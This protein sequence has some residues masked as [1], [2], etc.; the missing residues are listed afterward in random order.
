MNKTL[1]LATVLILSSVMSCDDGS[2]PSSTSGAAS[3]DCPLG[4]FKPI[5]LSECV[6]PADTEFGQPTTVSD[7]RCATGQPAIPPSC[8]SDTGRRAYL[9][10]SSTCAPNYHF[11]MG[12]C[13]RG[14]TG[15]GGFFTAGT[16]GAAGFGFA[17]STDTGGF[18]G[19]AGSTGFAG[20]TGFAGSTGEGGATGTGGLSG[21][22][23][24]TGSAGV[25]GAAG[26]TGSDAS[27]DAQSAD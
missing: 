3:G 16:T 25:T 12:L 8:V 18:T 14:N 4:M 10:A 7:N 26:I 20:F 9:S 2:D 17:G 24:V 6:F 15:I 22:S 27:T 1:G 13:Q 11:E 5:G 23:G 21:G 19:G